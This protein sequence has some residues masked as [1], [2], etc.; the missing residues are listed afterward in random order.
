MLRVKVK[1]Y[2]PTLR[3]SPAMLRVLL[4]KND[5]NKHDNAP[6]LNI[7]YIVVEN[8][9]YLGN[10]HFNTRNTIGAICDT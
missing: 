4:Q 1:L 3:F 9:T 2:N 8:E 5:S 6:M 10:R 7:T